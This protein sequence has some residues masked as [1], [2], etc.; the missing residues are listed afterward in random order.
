M[1]AIDYMEKQL[2]KNQRI[3]NSEFKRGAPE[4]ILRNIEKKISYYQAAVDALKAKEG[5]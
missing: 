2:R 5:K 1:T 3:Y 4:E